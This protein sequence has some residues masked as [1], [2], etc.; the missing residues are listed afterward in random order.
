[1]TPPNPTLAEL[2]EQLFVQPGVAPGATAAVAKRGPQGWQLHLAA[3]GS[4][5][6]A[7][8]SSP[9][10]SVPVQ[11]DTLYD[12][13]SVTKPVVA[14]LCARLAAIGMLPLSTPLG[15]WVAEARN[16][17]SEHLSLETLLSH[18]AGLLAHLDLFEPLRRREQLVPSFAVHAAA[19]ARRSECSGELPEQGFPPLYSDLGYLLVGEAVQRATQRNLDELI[20]EHVNRPCNTTLF[21]A[22]QWRAKD[23]AFQAR[24][25]P[26]EWVT[27]RG[28]FVHGIVHDE[29]AWALAREGCA[30]NAGLFADA[31]NV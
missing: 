8:P 6:P 17:P 13:A 22:R 26:T 31:A 19:S 10:A 12:L 15:T 23:P 9:M 28:G 7:S 11:T 20:D 30:G 27:W 3:V 1:M 4:L 2:L 16:T 24:T 29:N 18:R 25:A 5:G 14:L 21:S